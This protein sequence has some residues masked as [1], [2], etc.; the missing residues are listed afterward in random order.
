M[1]DLIYDEN[2]PIPYIDARIHAAFEAA[3]YSNVSIERFD[4]TTNVYASDTRGGR[5]FFDFEAGSDDDGSM[6]FCDVDANFADVEVVLF[7]ED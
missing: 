5:V 6:I 3:G 4:E 1:T 2:D 7:P